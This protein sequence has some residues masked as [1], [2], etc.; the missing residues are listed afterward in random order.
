M[1]ILLVLY[2]DYSDFTFFVWSVAVPGWGREGGGGRVEGVNIENVN[3]A[4]YWFSGLVVRTS[5]NGTQNASLLGTQ[6]Q[7]IDRGKSL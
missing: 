7:G 5:Q 1:C 2:V 6:H 4:L 3:E